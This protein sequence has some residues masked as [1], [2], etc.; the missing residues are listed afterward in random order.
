VTNGKKVLRKEKSAR[1]HTKDYLAPGDVTY[2]L[3]PFLCSA[4]PEEAP[5]GMALPYLRSLAEFR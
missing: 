3:W 1:F 2:T 4:T 5:V